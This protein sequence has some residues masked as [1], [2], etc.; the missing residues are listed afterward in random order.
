MSRSLSTCMRRCMSWKSG[1]E[2]SNTTS[3]P[4]STTSVLPSA[5]PSAQLGIAMRDVA[6]AAVHEPH[7]PAFDGREAAHAVPLHLERPTRPG[8]HGRCRRREHRSHL[9]RHGHAPG[10][11]RRI[12]PV[13]DP[14]LAV[15]LEERVPTLHPLAVEGHDD[16]VV[17]QLVDLVLAAVPDAHR[18][19]A[20]VAVGDV[21]LEVEVLERMVFG[22]HREVIALR[23]RRDALR[24]RPR[25]QH[26]VVLEPEVP[27]QRARGAPARRSGPARAALRSFAVTRRFGRRREVALGAVLVERRRGLPFAGHTTSTPP[28]RSRYLPHT[29][30]P[31]PPP[32]GTWVRQSGRARCL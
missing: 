12:H 11:R 1:R 28:P 25:Q 23:C 27:V 13:D 9:R 16:L 6:A 15:G 4:S 5:R 31:P 24:H 21:A 7:P 18:A 3:S 8:R 32:G 10:I 17:A 19:R 22:V 20:V 14:V 30:R 2:P 29:P 26:A